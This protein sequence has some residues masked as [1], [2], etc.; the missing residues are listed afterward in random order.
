VGKQDAKGKEAAQEGAAK[1]VT[2][3]ERKAKKEAKAKEIAERKTKAKEKSDAAIAKIKEIINK[4]LGIA[5]NYEQQLKDDKAFF[6][7]IKDIIVANI[8]LGAANFNQIVSDISNAIGKPLSASARAA[9]KALFNKELLKAYRNTYNALSAVQKKKMDAARDGVRRSMVSEIKDM[10]NPRKWEQKAEKIGK[11]KIDKEA[12]GM[13]SQIAKSLDGVDLSSFDDASLQDL[14]NA[15]SDVFESGK[16]NQKDLL[17]LMKEAERIKGAQFAEMIGEKKKTI[18]QNASFDVAV[19]VLN[20]DVVVKIGGR[21]Y[22]KADLDAFID[23]F[24][25]LDSLLA[26]AISLVAKQDKFLS[27]NLNTRRSES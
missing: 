5:F 25:D 10:I 26:L 27:T 4:P 12:G 11:A 23:L 13:L 1:E 16:A 17:G 2:K 24:E 6:G 3:E 15:L 18:K 7:A 9:T 22:T 8:D 19:G 14:Y 20:D 21:Y